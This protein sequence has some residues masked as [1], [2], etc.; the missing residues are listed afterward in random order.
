M[1]TPGDAI[2]IE[3]SKK[4]LKK[5]E[6]CPRCGSENIVPILANWCEP[7]YFGYI[8]RQCFPE[9]SQSDHSQPAVL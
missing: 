9:Q 3:D 1:E 6:C 4:E 5:P 2:F 8:C 7:P